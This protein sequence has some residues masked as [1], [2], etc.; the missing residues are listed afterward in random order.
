MTN[1]NNVYKH[2]AKNPWTPVEYMVRREVA[3]AAVE[4]LKA[5]GKKTRVTSTFVKRQRVRVWSVWTVEV[6]VIKE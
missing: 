2:M 4:R 1:P 6:P 5:E 3:D